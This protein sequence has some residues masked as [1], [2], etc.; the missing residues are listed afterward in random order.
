M[1]AGL[2][3]LEERVSFL[4]SR[5]SVDDLDR[6]AENLE[7]FVRSDHWQN[8]ATS[9]GVEGKDHRMSSRHVRGREITRQEYEA[10]YVEDP[11][12][13]RI[14]DGVPEHGTRRWITVTAVDTESDGDV[15]ADFSQEV[16]DALEDLDAQ[17]QFYE[18]WRLAR[19]DGGA[20][21]VVVA[22]DGLS[23]DQP[24][25]LSRVNTLDALN[26]VT[27]F[28]LFPERIN[29]D[30]TS[31]RYRQPEFYRFTG[32]GSARSAALE[33]GPEDS[34]EA[35]AAGQAVRSREGAPDARQYTAGLIHHSRVIR[36]RGITLSD[37][38]D[39]ALATHVHE[40]FYWG[41]SIVQRVYDDL[42]QF[43]TIYAYVEAGFKDMS[44]GVYGMKNL[45]ELLSVTD[46]N[47]ALI[48]RMTLIALAASTF[49][50]VL[51]DPEF[52]SYEKR[53][54][55][56]SNVDAVM[57]R[58]MEKLAAAAEMP[59]TKLFGIS[60]SGLS[61]DDQSGERTFHATISSKQRKKLRKPIKRV[62]DILLHA[63]RGPTSGVV[64]EKWK[65]EFV[66]LDEPNETEDANRRK[67]DAETDKIH[68]ENGTL[69]LHEVRT[70]LRNDPDTPYTLDPKVDEAMEAAAQ[71]A[72]NDIEEGLQIGLPMADPDRDPAS[73]LEG[74]DGD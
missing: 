44:Q 35:R 9:L 1:T 17:Q 56:F 22:D 74:V 66:S 26:V 29:D 39:R 59:V 27:R 28:E 20:A 25:D 58:F 10:M 45:S 38:M 65:Y 42:R 63:K 64:P 61:T 37:T 68:L 46:S 19:L 2:E 32:R 47:A 5:L 15:E 55:Q 34:A 71:P 6:A 69:E 43:N 51:Y 41:S 7:R 21:M 8:V 12:F 30:I 53:P 13:A 57:I 52:E 31:P 16:M 67:T 4:K 18:L 40:D 33:G 24:L 62:I 60:P 50:M 49:N 14:V 36:M 23:P 72:D 3:T 54:G 11:I 70:R 48:R 73:A